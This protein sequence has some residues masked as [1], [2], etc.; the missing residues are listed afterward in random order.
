MDFNGYGG[1]I[2]LI[3]LA[4]DILA[5][6]NIVSSGRSLGS[7]FLWILFVLVLPLLGMI[8]YFLIGRK[9]TA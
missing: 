3:I 2:G 8:I 5:I 6:A 7:K 1:L 4:L 9:S